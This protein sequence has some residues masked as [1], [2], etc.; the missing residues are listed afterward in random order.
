MLISSVSTQSMRAIRASDIKVIKYLASGGYGTVNEE[1][2]LNPPDDVVAVAGPVHFVANPSHPPANDA[3]DSS[4]VTSDHQGRSSLVPAV[5]VAVKYVQVLEK[6]G[7][8][9]SRK[10]LDSLRKE[11]HVRYKRGSGAHS[12]FGYA[13]VAVE[14]HRLLCHLLPA[15]PE[16]HSAPPHYPLL[17]HLCG[18]AECLP[19]HA[20]SR[21]WQPA[22]AAVLAA[23]WVHPSAGN[24]NWAVPQ[25][26]AAVQ[27][28][29][30]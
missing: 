24:R 10:L 20:A 29:E 15:G 6:D 14:F 25:R 9:Y 1:W 19:G 7:A 23:Q 16:S 28:G 26:S 27:R 11:I 30:A 8:T 5:K 21:E 13:L 18:A 3:A 12:G 17:W 22:Q 4:G 2:W